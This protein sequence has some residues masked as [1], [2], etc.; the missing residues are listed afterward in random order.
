MIRMTWPEYLRCECLYYGQ[1]VRLSPLQASVLAVL[2]MN[3]GEQI[4]VR[5]MVECVWPHPDDQPDWA[6]DLAR[7][8]VFQLRQK[9]P[10]L[11]EY[12]GLYESHRG[13]YVI[14]RP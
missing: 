10:G 5:E 6:Y 13:G 4:P 8:M 14:R 2:L 9:M 3:R 7:K 1:R 12:E 11:I